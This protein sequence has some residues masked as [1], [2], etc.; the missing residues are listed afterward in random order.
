MC[1]WN[2]YVNPSTDTI[3]VGNIG[4]GDVSRI[5]GRACPPTHIL[6]LR[7]EPIPARLGDWG[8]AIALDPTA[9]GACVPNNGD[10]P[11]RCSRS[12]AEG[13]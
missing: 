6:D 7:P 11:S 13:Q 10:V 8:M 2:V 9:S 3:Y 1:T 5:D 4:D 12:G